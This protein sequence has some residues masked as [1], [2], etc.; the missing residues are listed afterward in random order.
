MSDPFLAA[1]LPAAWRGV[2]FD[3][4]AYRDATGIGDIGPL[5]TT[6]RPGDKLK[7]LYVLRMFTKPPYP[8]VPAG[9]VAPANETPRA[10]FDFSTLPP[11]QLRYLAAQC[12]E[13][14][15]CLGTWWA[16]FIRRR[17]DTINDF[18]LDGFD[19]VTRQ[20]DRTARVSRSSAGRWWKRS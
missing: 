16:T 9:A 11:E 3:T 8:D 20:A 2:P 19:R 6:L 12:P 17:G 10:R 4:G 15:V 18:T 5:A 7:F 14:S 13:D 1:L